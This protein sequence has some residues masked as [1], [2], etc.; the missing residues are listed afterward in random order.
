MAGWE[1]VASFHRSETQGA[2]LLLS[3]KVLSARLQP[4]KHPAIVISEIVELLAALDDVGI[5]VHEEFIWLHFVYNLPPG[6]EFI[7]NNLQG[8]KEPITRTVLEDTLRSR[9][10]VQPG[11]KKGKTIPDSELFVSDLK[12]GRGVRRGGGRGGTYKGKLDSKGRSEG[13]AIIAKSPGTFDQTVPNVNTSSAKDGVTRLFPAH[14]RF[15]LR[16]R[17]ETKRRMSQL[18]WR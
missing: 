14:L 5:P 11:G 6:Y 3:R 4:G 9:Y 18:L 12:P 2:K 8:S 1:R 15:R 7:K 10:N 13:P 17:M 16:T